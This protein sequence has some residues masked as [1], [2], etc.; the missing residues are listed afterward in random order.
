MVRE[1]NY[2]TAPGSGCNSIAKFFQSAQASW[3]RQSALEAPRLPG[4]GHFVLPASFALLGFCWHLPYKVAQ[5][6]QAIGTVLRLPV[7]WQHV[8]VSGQLNRLRV[9]NG[10]GKRV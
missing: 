8:R 9:R 10:N 2:N 1:P 3:I 7:N 5:Q 4:V 6:H